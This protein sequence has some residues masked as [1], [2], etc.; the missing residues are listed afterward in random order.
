MLSSYEADSCRMRNAATVVI[1]RVIVCHTTA[2]YDERP[3]LTGQWT[4]PFEAT[5]AAALG[6]E[7]SWTGT[8]DEGEGRVGDLSPTA[9]DG[10]EQASRAGRP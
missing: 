6:L 2:P 1:L 8:L 5:T 7:R 9:V 10:E 4:P 3:T